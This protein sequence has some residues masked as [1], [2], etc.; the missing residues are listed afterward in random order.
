MRRRVVGIRGQGSFGFGSARRQ[1]VSLKVGTSG[2]TSTSGASG[3]I[4]RARESSL[5]AFRSS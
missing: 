5:K 2:V 3:L 1:P 4:C